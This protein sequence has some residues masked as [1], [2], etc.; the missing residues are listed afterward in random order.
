LFG[1]E[2]CERRL[3][4]TLSDAPT[5]MPECCEDGPG[6]FAAAKVRCHGLAVSDIFFLTS[7]K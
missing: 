7:A 6:A 1:S 4:M 2:T 3:T 5:G